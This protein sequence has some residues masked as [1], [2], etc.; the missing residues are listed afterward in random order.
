M[1]IGASG[2]LLHNDGIFVFIYG[3]VF[4][5]IEDIALRIEVRKLPSL[6]S[7]ATRRLSLRLYLMCVQVNC[8]R[9]A[10]TISGSGKVSAK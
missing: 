8:L 2:S 6:R 5:F 1:F 3:V 4:G 7:I 10:E 9:S